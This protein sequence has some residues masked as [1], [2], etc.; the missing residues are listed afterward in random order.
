MRYQSRLIG[1]VAILVVV[2]AAPACAGARSS[3][4]ASGASIPIKDVSSVAGTWGGLVSRATGS[5]EGDWLEM[6]VKE[7]GTFQAVSARQIGLLLGNGTLAIRNGQMA[8]V[9]PQGTAVL[10]LHDDRQGRALAMEFRDRNGVRYSGQLRP[11][12]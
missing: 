2:V 4:G 10:T 8:A 12:M 3:A 9:G 6:K 1:W 7:D 11:Q 5:D